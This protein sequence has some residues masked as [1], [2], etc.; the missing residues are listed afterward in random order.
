MEDEKGIINDDAELEHSIIEG[1]GEEYLDSEPVQSPREEVDEILDG[2]GS[3]ALQRMGVPKGFADKAIKKDGGTFSPGNLPGR[4]FLKNKSRNALANGLGGVVPPSKKNLGLNEKQS[5]EE[6]KDGESKNNPKEVSQK[7]SALPNKEVIKN[8]GKEAGKEAAKNGAKAIA[9]KAAIA[10]FTNPITY[11]VLGGIFLLFIIIVIVS[12]DASASN[13]YGYCNAN[14]D[15]MS[16]KQ[17]SLSKSDFVSKVR[18]YFA[19]GT[20]DAANVFYENAEIIYDI[21]QDIGINPEMVVIRAIAEGFSPGTSKNNYWGMGCYNGSNSC[22]TYSSFEDGVR[23]FSENISQYE[24]VTAMA[25]KYA[26]IGRYWYNPG[27]SALG[28]CYYFPYIREF[29]SEGRASEVEKICNG[30]ECTTSGGECTETTEEDQNAYATWQVQ[31]MLEIRTRVFDLEPD[32]CNDKCY[33]GDYSIDPD[34][35]LYGGLQLLHGTSFTELLEANNMTVESYNEFLT[36]SIEKAGVGT[37]D[38]VIAAATSLIGS[39]AEMGYKLNYQW[40][41][42]YSN[43]GINSNWGNRLPAAVI[44]NN[45]SSHESQYGPN[46]CV[47]NYA[48]YGFDCT[49]F[50]DWVV[51]NGMQDATITHNDILASTHI[52]L[53]KNRAVCKPGGSLASE[54]EGHRVLVVGIDDEKKQYIVA[55]ATGSR[56]DQNSGGVKISRYSYGKS[57]YF[58]QNFENIYND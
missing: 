50:V 55:E 43:I 56:I 34:D 24:S 36:E 11:F 57:D 53:D 42:K 14:C 4:K 18:E 6:T 20:S 16:I 23:G 35:E 32:A 21:A 39:I 27:D 45:C 7:P 54:K 40:G 52:S 10:L 9:K 41:G 44:N 49:G 28:G 1:D 22:I 3:E 58:C 17:T 47:N 26:Y 12:G 48:W 13:I 31:K 8:A 29:M 19:N 37:R 38:G 2:A 46:T 25:S 33:S 5:E 30:S 15:G 51:I